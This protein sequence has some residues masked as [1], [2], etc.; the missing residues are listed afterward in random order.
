MV[1]EARAGGLNPERS[2]RLTCLQV[3]GLGL[4]L[5]VRLGSWEALGGPGKVASPRP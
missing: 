1:L 3:Q 2:C 4:A 5:A